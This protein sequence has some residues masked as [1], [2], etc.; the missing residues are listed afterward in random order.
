MA[1][2][3]KHF[4]FGSNSLWGKLMR[5]LGIIKDAPA[6]APSV[7][8][9]PVPPSPPAPPPPPIPPT[10]PVI[11]LPPQPGRDA[12]CKIK[13]AFQGVTVVTQQLGSVPSWGPEVWMLTSLADRQAVYAA[14]K[15]WGATHIVVAIAGSYVEAGVAYPNNCAMNNNYFTDLP[16]MYSRLVEIILNGLIPVLML[17][18]DDGFDKIYTN[19]PAVVKQIRTG[20]QGDLTPHLVY[21]SGFDSIDGIGL[22]Q[23][24]DNGATLDQLL[25]YIRQQIGP[26]AVQAKENAMLAF[27]SGA[28]G[29]LGG[30]YSGPGA[31][32]CDVF[33]FESQNISPGNDPAPL[34]IG[35]TW[36][37]EHNDYA[38]VWNK[39]ESCWTQIWQDLSRL[40][41]NGNNYTAPPDQPFNIMVPCTGSATNASW[42]GTAS[43]SSD[44]R[45]HA[46]Y[47]GIGCPRGRFYSC[48]FEYGTYQWTHGQCTAQ[49]VQNARNYLAAIGLDQVC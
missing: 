34:I 44:S 40:I 3:V 27:W 16:T 49:Q 14:H 33:L 47:I 46:S 23:Y 19:L 39:S 43:V 17:D 1:W 2:N 31:Q 6:P 25:V 29:P 37:S 32:A 5:T 8:V 42:S 12:L 28:T 35:G 9:K 36:D 20:P 13:A 24:H 11:V 15:A 22:G 4:L 21:C 7:P 48:A 30:P 45:G 26:D 18:G 10:P 41:P 38:P